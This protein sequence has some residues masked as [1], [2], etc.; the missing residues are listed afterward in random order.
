MST[1]STATSPNVSWTDDSPP[2]HKSTH[3]DKLR[4]KSSAKK[5]P[6]VTPK[7]IPKKR[8]VKG[9]TEEQA[10]H[11][12]AVMSQHAMY[13]G[14]DDDWEPPKEN[15]KFCM[16]LDRISVHEEFD[17]AFEF[18]PRHPGTHDQLEPLEDYD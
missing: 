17:I 2:Q 7:A 6:K 18:G 16:N 4:K 11:D 5:S 13:M 15:K 12:A 10:R 14:S 9:L 3:L 8:K 1:A